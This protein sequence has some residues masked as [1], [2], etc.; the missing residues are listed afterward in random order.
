V[1]SVG[2]PNR[3]S[4]RS[5]RRRRRDRIPLITTARLLG[6]FNPPT[7]TLLIGNPLAV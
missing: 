3:A 6:V 7:H 1:E 5:C 4:C 2:L